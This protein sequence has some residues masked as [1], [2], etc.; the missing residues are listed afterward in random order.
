MQKY[1]DNCSSFSIFQKQFI[2]MTKMITRNQLERDMLIVSQVWK[3]KSLL[4]HGASPRNTSSRLSTTPKSMLIKCRWC[5][6]IF[7]V[8]TFMFQKIG[9]NSEES[10]GE[11][12]RRYILAR[13]QRGNHYSLLEHRHAWCS[14]RL[15]INH[16]KK[17]V[18]GMPMIYL[19]HTF[20]FQKIVSNSMLRV[21][22][23]FIIF[24]LTA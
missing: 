21:S 9:S 20:I 3:G 7:T 22:L 2:M 8:H 6:I 17:H 19:Q 18:N 14:S 11:R 16:A 15:Y 13:F 10:I 1:V 4:A 23:F 5:I 24:N 12:S